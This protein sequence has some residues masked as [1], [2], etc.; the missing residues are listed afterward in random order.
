MDVLLEAA[1][2]QLGCDAGPPLESATAVA[3]SVELGSSA[4]RGAAPTA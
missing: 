3:R 2:A 4:N 1:S